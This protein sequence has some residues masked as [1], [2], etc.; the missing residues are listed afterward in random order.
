M[1]QRRPKGDGALYKRADG[2]WIG[3]VNLVGRNGVRTKKTVSGRD[4]NVVAA[5]LKQLQRDIDDGLMPVAPTATVESW[6]VRWLDEIARPRLKPRTYATYRSV[7]K[8]HLIPELGHKRLATL[9]PCDIRRM[10]ITISGHRS[11]RTTQIAYNVLAKALKDAVREGLIRSNPCDRVDRPTALHQEREAMSI[12]DIR[13]L[14]QY[15]AT[16]GDD[17]M[18]SRTAMALLTGARQGECL[19][20]EWE[21]VDFDTKMIDIS[22]TL[23]RVKLTKTQRPLFDQYPRDMFDVPPAFDFRPVWR[24]FCLVPP[25]TARSRRIVPMIPTLEAALLAHRANTTGTGLVWT[26]PG[27]APLLDRDDSK[28]WRDTLTA[29]GLADADGNVPTLHSARH[30]VATLLQG[31]G[32]DEAVRM[33]LLGH[34]SVAAHRGYAHV[35]QTL[36]R[37]ALGELSKLI[38]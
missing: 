10:T 32:V 25:K 6:L 5:R 36:T 13:A 21:R 20:L 19:G 33:Q 11:T 23:Q 30:T 15:L 27:G 18:V 31:A 22:W 28:A 9:Q 17:P 1:G 29:A 24:S 8:T 16:L 35:D 26:R 12:P 7:V 3:A 4:R 38:A 34:S 37:A 14:F 2:V